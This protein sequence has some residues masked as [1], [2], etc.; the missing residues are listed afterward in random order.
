MRAHLPEDLAIDPFIFMDESGRW[1]AS[2]QT[3][4]RVGVIHVFGETKNVA[5]E[6]AEALILALGKGKYFEKKYK[7]LMETT[8]NTSEEVSNGKKPI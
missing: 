7:E 1:V 4:N 3:E 2:I 8:D 6:R 5:S